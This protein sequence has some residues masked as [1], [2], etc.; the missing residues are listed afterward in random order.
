[1]AEKLNKKRDA[2]QSKH[3]NIIHLK[4]LLAPTQKAGFAA[5]KTLK[6]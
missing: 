3:Q 1:M 6:R 5:R 4:Q 2:L